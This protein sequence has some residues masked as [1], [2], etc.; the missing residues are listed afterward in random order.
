MKA[1][2]LY[3]KLIENWKIKAGCFAIA[4]FLYVVYQTQSIDKRVFS[5]PLTVEAKNGFV[6]VE[7]Q[8]RTVAVT[9]RGKSEELAQVRDTDL[10][11]YLDLNYV[12]KD[13]SYDFPILLTLSDTASILNPLELKVS[14]E[15]VKLRVEEE[16]TSFADI[17]P[18]ISGNPGYGCSIKSISV[19][20]D[21]IA[22]RGPRSMVENCKSL[23]TLSVTA[24]GAKRSFSAKTKV[25]QKGLFI[26]HADTEVNVTVEIE[27]LEGCRQFT[28]LP[29]KIE[30]LSPE[31]EISTITDDI[32]VTLKGSMVLLE[33]F[34]PEE[35]F[36]FADVSSINA[37]GT[38]DIPIQYNVPK[39]FEL[40]EG[41]TKTIP[42]T[43]VQKKKPGTEA[44]EEKITVL[45]SSGGILEEKVER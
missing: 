3:E 6:A 16:I 26:K 45:E 38:F 17:V 44:V 29:V 27:E 40:G 7:S 2:Q 24:S 25:E 21:Q 33:A 35:N 1:K 41:Y 20:P 4:L 42:V 19:V 43:F 36:V 22:I 28:K 23:K 10:K 30:N 13:G 32:M 15:S 31:L 12:S 14:P 5:V 9:A 37:A 11:A 18:L 8:P 34:V 39:G